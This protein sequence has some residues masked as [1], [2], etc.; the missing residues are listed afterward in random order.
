MTS[1]RNLPLAAR[2]GGAFG[3]L[4]LAL[5]VVAFTGVSAMN[6]LRATSD[7][8]GDRHLMVAE[9]FGTMQSRAKDNLGLVSQHL[10]V[11]DGNLAAQDKLVKDLEANWAKNA[12]DGAALAKLLAGTP[13]ES[14]YAEFAAERAQFVELQ[15]SALED[16]RRETVE[17]VEERTASRTTFEGEL[18]QRDADS[19]PP[20]SASWTS[21]AP[22]P[23]KASRPRTPAPP[24]A[25]A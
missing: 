7:E 25:P 9:L 16:S 23:R 12:Q 2:L 17:N 6:G 24:P 11:L 3:A 13:I 18:L 19:R 10:Y 21:R 15:K 4:C 20:P 8:L 14:T 5:V 22:L 1:I